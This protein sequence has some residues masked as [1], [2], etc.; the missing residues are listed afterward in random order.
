MPVDKIDADVIAVTFFED[1]RPLRGTAGMVDWRLNG[2]LSRLILNGTTCGK[3]GESLLLATN[4]R[5][6]CSRLLMFG[7]GDSR[8]FDA[9]RFQLAMSTF[10]TTVARLRFSRIA[11]AIPGSS[12]FSMEKVSESIIKEFEESGMPA[13][14]EVIIIN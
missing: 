1:E 3:E 8:Q 5:M 6:S 2:A 4:G 9:K 12:M 7:L 14:T 13:D 11:I 10:V